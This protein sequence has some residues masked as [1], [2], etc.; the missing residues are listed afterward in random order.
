MT[1][2]YE[3][4]PVT[5]VGRCGAGEGQRRG[6]V[7]DLDGLAAA[8]DNDGRRTGCGLGV[9]MAW[10]SGTTTAPC[11]PPWL[12]R[13]GEVAQGGPPGPPD[14][15]HTGTAGV[16]GYPAAQARTPVPVCAGQGVDPPPIRP[17]SG[18]LRAVGTTGQGSVARAR[19]V[20]T[21]KG[22]APARAT[23]AFV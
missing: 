23:L 16:S 8:P 12:G 14:G 22:R 1:P 15:A 19:A 2:Y 17:D 7:R 6:A 13:A 20:V 21:G 11:D 18:P 5:I 9:A 4:G 3:D 10:Y